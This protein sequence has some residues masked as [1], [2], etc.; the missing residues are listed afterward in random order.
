MGRF[1]I[2]FLCGEK[3][4]FYH[5]SQKYCGHRDAINT[6]AWKVSNLQR[7]Y[8]GMTERCYN[9]T[10]QNYKLYKKVGICNEWL[11]DSFKFVKW[12]LKNGWKKELQIDR[13]ENSKGYEPVNCRFI[14]RSENCRNKVKINTDWKHKTRRCRICKKRKPFSKFMIHRKEIGGI[15]YECRLCRKQLDK[16]RYL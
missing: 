15:A 2:C 1:K 7:I 14:T 6:C 12:A 16:L 8:V 11:S 9:P 5:H 4:S 10:N 13:K 3:F